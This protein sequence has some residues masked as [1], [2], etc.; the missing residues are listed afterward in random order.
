MIKQEVRR[1]QLEDASTA[2][3]ASLPS[4]YT[5]SICIVGERAKREMPIRPL[6]PILAKSRNFIIHATQIAA[7]PPVGWHIDLER[8]AQAYNAIHVNKLRSGTVFDKH[9]LVEETVSKGANGKHPC[10]IGR[11][12]CAVHAFAGALF[13]AVD[14]LEGAWLTSSTGAAVMTVIP[15]I[16]QASCNITTSQHGERIVRAVKTLVIAAHSNASR[17]RSSLA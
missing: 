11:T 6:N 13:C 4:I 8:A 2:L 15:S 5:D 10:N 1:W 16:A 7:A 12:D 17:V 3:T 14:C 9:Y